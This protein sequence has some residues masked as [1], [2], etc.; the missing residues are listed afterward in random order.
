MSGSFAV[1]TSR[2]R[3]EDISVGGWFRCQCVF[4][5]HHQL[6]HPR[7]GYVQQCRLNAFVL[8]L[9]TVFVQIIEKRSTT[10]RK[11]LKRS[12]II[13]DNLYE[14]DADRPLKKVAFC[15][16]C[17]QTPSYTHPTATKVCICWFLCTRYPDI[18]GGKLASKPFRGSETHTH[19]QQ[20]IKIPFKKKTQHTFPEQLVCLLRLSS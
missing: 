13:V 17:I 6:A 9:Y 14:Y 16:L 7:V 2:S 10:S 20:P 5:W 18:Q 15:C 3:R 12:N 8:K 19:N 4:L 11:I 1:T